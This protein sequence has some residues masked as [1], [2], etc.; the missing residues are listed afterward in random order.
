MPTPRPFK[1]MLAETCEDADRAALPFPLYATPKIDGLRCLVI[2]GVATSRSLKPIPNRFVQ[3]V[4]G[5]HLLDGLDGELVVG[6][7]FQD[8]TSGLMSEDGE[9]DFRYYVFDHFHA[10][11]ESYLDRVE[12]VKA[13]IA[14]AIASGF[15]GERLIPLYPE[16][17]S[18]AD[19]LEAYCNFNLEGGFEGTMVRRGDGPYKYGR[20]TLREGYLLKLKPFV[21]SE[22]VVIGFEEQMHNGN[23]AEINAL[24]HTERSSHKANLTPTGVLGALIVTTDKFGQFNLGTGFT[25]E[26]RREIWTHRDQYV[27]HLAKFKY[28]ACGTKDKPRI[29]TFLGWRDERDL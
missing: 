5:T 2:D 4:L 16:E 20:S 12:R 8:V 23:T 22:A 14:R 26:Q 21:D 13:T 7:T 29:P 6:E 15:P 27:G 11:G 17:L 28:Q 1:P 19:D 10:P 25:A 3:S 18:G 9:P 24:G